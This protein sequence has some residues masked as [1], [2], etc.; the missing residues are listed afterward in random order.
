MNSR[1]HPARVV[2]ALGQGDDMERSGVESLV[3]VI[4]DEVVRAEMQFETHAGGVR[5][6]CVHVS[7]V[8]RTIDAIGETLRRQVLAPSMTR[9]LK[10]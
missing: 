8:K 10:A 1:L 5:H 7:E 4:R 6:G 2:Q 9:I 3:A